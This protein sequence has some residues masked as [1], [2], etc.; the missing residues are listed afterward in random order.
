[1][2]KVH[3]I[4]IGADTRAFED[5]VKRG[6]IDPTED[7]E[8]ALQKLGDT[9]AGKDAARDLDKLEDALKDAQRESKDLGKKLGD[10][11]DSAK[12]GMGEA[13]EGVKNFKE[14]AASSAR[15]SAASFDG[16]F[17]SIA[18]V[19]QEIAANAFS[20]FGPAGT[21]A[22]IAVA[23][24]AGVMIDAF[25]KVEE[26]A[27]EARDSAFSLAYDVSG[28]LESAGY[29][30][31]IAEWSSETEKYKQVTELATASGWDEVEVID[32]LASGGSKLD[33]LTQAFA[34]HGGQTMIT[35]GRLSELD[36][37]LKA[38][39]DGYISGADAAKLAE[40][41]NYEYAMTVGVATGE[42]DALGNAIYK[43][44]DDTEVAV[45]AKTKTATDD[46]ARVDKAIDDVPDT[47]TTTFKAKTMLEGAR[48]EIS[49]FIASQDGKSFK[50]NARVVTSGTRWD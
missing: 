21:A 46:I 44:P 41:A 25:G 50:I 26:A 1:M 45:N 17:E 31:R 29:T 8:K 30:S 6:V 2:A 35:N 39:R 33:D 11:G 5:Q 23:A 14:E 18:E 32:A 20:G 15:E 10:V 3:E 13:E 36:A 16:S 12:R 43:L 38:T 4:G 37:V 7:A 47:H 42:T 9:D 22:G 24:G 34:D 28:A 49:N 27:N 48:R 40:K 19:G